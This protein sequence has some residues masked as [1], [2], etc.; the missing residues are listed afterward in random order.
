L[1]WE[2]LFAQ[3]AP[4]DLKYHLNGSY[5][6]L[7]KLSPRLADGPEKTKALP[8]ISSTG[9]GKENKFYASFGTQRSPGPRPKPRAEIKQSP[10]RTW[11]SRCMTLEEPQ[12][13]DAAERPHLP[14]FFF[15]PSTSN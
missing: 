15:L 1:L 2:F 5:P 7:M 10:W 8:K 4:K 11:G 9:K 6:W 12:S 14:F 13:H 3:V